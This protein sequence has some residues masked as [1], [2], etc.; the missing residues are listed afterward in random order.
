MYALEVKR[1]EKVFWNDFRLNISFSLPQGCIMGL[2]GTNGAGKST[3]IKLILDML[4]KDSGEIRILGK[5]ASIGIEYIKQNLGVVM[6]EAGVPKVFTV[7]KIEN[8][9]K[10]L[11]IRWD[12]REFHRLLTL[13]DIPIDKPYEALST[14]TKVKLH[15]AIAM[16]HHAKLLLLDEPM[17]GLDPMTRDQVVELLLDFTRDEEHSVLISSHIVS[18]LEKICDYVGFLHKGE[19]LVFAEKDALL[20]DYCRVQYTHEELPL[21]K[22]TPLLHVRETPYGI[23]AIAKRDG[24]PT[25]LQR[26]N[27]GLEELFVSMIKE[28]KA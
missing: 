12:H 11:Y 15:I 6:N 10:H 13:F 28:A 16:S 23:E 7:K 2:I 18:D 14:G 19:L 9:M 17:N 20:A 26:C 5:D 21:L 22:E 1:L 3:T 25:E 24:L 27:V 8:I 4:Y